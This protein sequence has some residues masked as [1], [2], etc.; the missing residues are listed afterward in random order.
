MKKGACACFSGHAPGADKMEAAPEAEG[1]KQYEVGWGGDRG[2]FWL[3]AVCGTHHLSVATYY[4]GWTSQPPPC[5]IPSSKAHRP[6]AEA[7][8]G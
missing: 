2:C 3:R 8:A 1:S 6:Q 5:P 4:R 7:K